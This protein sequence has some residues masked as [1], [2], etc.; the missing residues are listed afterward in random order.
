[1][2]LN[3]K[4]VIAAAKK[5]LRAEHIKK[6]EKKIRRAAE[7]RQQALE[8]RLNLECEQEVEAKSGCRHT[9]HGKWC[10]YNYPQLIEQWRK[11]EERSALKLEKYQH[12]YQR[13]LEREGL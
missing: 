10:I 4:T 5:Q 13:Y 8:H 1:M 3:P 7:L 2:T 11:L 12:Y 9:Y 6:Y